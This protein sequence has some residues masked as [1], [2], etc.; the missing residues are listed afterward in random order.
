MRIR[1]FFRGEDGVSAVPRLRIVPFIKIVEGDKL[2][3]SEER[4]V[5]IASDALH[6]P[7]KL[8]SLPQDDK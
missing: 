7:E 2:C 1:E 6:S 3:L 5:R 8:R 4:H